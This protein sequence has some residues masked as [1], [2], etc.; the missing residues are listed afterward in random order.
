[1]RVRFLLMAFMASAIAGAEY[2]IWDYGKDCKDSLGVE[3]PSFSCLDPNAAELPVT[4]NGKRVA[5]DAGRPASCDKPAHVSSRC[6]PGERLLKIVDYIT[7]NGRTEK[8]VTV[9]HCRRHSRQES[10]SPLFEVALIQHNETNNKTCWFNSGS[11]MKDSS[12]VPPP[13]R[14]GSERGKN[15]KA[16]AYWIEPTKMMN[17]VSCHDTSVWLRNPYTAQSDN[18]GK[19]LVRRVGEKD[20]SPG[21]GN[22]LPDYGKK[23]PGCNVGEKNLPRW[24]GRGSIIR[25]NPV[26]YEAKFGPQPQDKASVGTCTRCH[27]LGTANTCDMAKYAIGEKSSDKGSDLA[28]AFPNSHWMPPFQELPQRL[29]AIAPTGVHGEEKNPTGEELRRLREASARGF[30]DYYGPA[31][32][33]LAYCCANPNATVGIRERAVPICQNYFP[34]TKNPVDPCAPPW[35]DEQRRQHANH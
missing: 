3:V 29:R 2:S 19:G 33:A 16:D 24:T 27:Y 28:K 12:S 20:Y 15:Q 23:G 13:Y 32:R 30:G 5:S 14:D 21:E 1:M 31:L 6:R 34:Q 8:I 35:T 7:R 25:I 26:A 10:T 11:A 9:A 18:I 4:V 17:C 22:D